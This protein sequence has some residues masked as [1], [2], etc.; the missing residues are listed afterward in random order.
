MRGLTG[1]VA[2]VTGAGSGIGAAVAH[3]LGAEG[4]RVVLVDRDEAAA[5]RVAAGV[6]GETLTVL[7]D[8]SQPDDV[9]AYLRAAV[10]R[11]G[12]LDAVHLN[13][14][15]S[16]THAAFTDIDLADY[17]RTVEVNQRG[18]FLG[19]RAALGLLTE[20]GTGGSIVVTASL[21]GLR[22][23]AAIAPYVATKHAAIGLAR[24]AALAGAPAGIRVNAIAPGLIDTPMQ[25]GHLAAHTLADLHARSPLGRMGTPDEVAAAV[26]FLLSAEASYLTGAVLVVDGGLDA[27]DP[28]AP[29]TYPRSA[30]ADV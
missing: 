13:A 28:V 6:P 22:P 2:V 20:Q 23:S 10:D 5:D 27:T 3:R 7:A 8:V 24:S 4:M 29:T 19:L 17:D 21:A 26:A 11:F 18:V 9:E 16:G 1:R 30:H 14:G 12:Q 25:G 15:I